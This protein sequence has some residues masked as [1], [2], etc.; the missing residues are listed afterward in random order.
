M[1]KSMRCPK[2]RQLKAPLKRHGLQ[3]QKLPVVFPVSLLLH[4]SAIRIRAIDLSVL[5]VFGCAI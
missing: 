4:T 3:P 1:T 2:L 5:P